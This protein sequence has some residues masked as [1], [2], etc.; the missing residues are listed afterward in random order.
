MSNG[1]L[2]IL[3]PLYGLATDVYPSLG[4]LVGKITK[5]FQ[6]NLEALST[7]INFARELCV[8]GRKGT[9]QDQQDERVRKLH[10]YSQFS[11][12]AVNLTLDSTTSDERTI[13]WKHQKEL[14]SIAYLKNSFVPMRNCRGAV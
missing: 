5:I 3:S 6:P 11:T 12:V 9:V 14:E 13:N 10:Y 8:E 4:V 7:A 1:Q 2:R